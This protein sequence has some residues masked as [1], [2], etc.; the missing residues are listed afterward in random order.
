[1]AAVVPSPNQIPIF[2]ELEGTSPPRRRHLRV[3]P[4][5]LADLTARQRRAVTWGEGPLLVVAGAG[6]GKTTVLTRR[7]AWL[8]AEQRARPSEILA[9]T[10]TERAAAEMQERVDQLVPYGYADSVICTFHAFGD[11]LIRE[12]ALGA[13]LSD[14]V[15]VLSRPEQVTFLREHLDEL[16]LD[17][18]RPLGDPT[19][20]L[21][22]LAAHFS[23]ARDEDAS[24][25][26]YRAAA[27]RISARAAADPDDAALAEEAARQ[28]ELAAAYETYER[29]L[30]AADR[31]DFGDQVGLALRLLRDRADILA[32]ERGRYRYILVDEFQ[33]TNHAQFELVQL[34]APAPSGNVTVV[35]DDDQS[36]YRFRGAALSN[37]LGFRAA[38]RR[39]GRVVL[40]DNFR[41]PQPVLDAAYRLI[42]HNDPDRLE[43]RERIDKR[44]RARGTGKRADQGAAAVRSIAHATTSDEADGVAESIA[45]SLASGRRAADHAILVRGNRD[46]D[47]YL[48]ALSLRRIPWRFSGTAG[49]YRQPE[50][51]V[52]LSFLRAL[53]DPEDSVSLFDLATS[54]IF[55]LTPDQASRALNRAS[56]RHLGLEVALRQGL[57]D[58][59]RATLRGASAAI[60]QRLIA[61]LD[62][63]RELAARLDA[64]EILYRFV[65]S[66]GWLARLAL[67]ARDSGPERLQNVARLFDILRR[68]SGIL[69]DPRL[70]FLV[71]RLDVLIQAGDDPATA[72]ANV[73][74]AEAVHVLTC[75][76]AKG[77]EF[78]I[79]F[80]VGMAQD[81]F[82]TRARR[83][84][85]DLPDELVREVA[86]DGDYHLAE[87]R[88]LCYVGM[89]RAR[90]SLVMSW[91]RD[92][93]E[94]PRRPSQFLLE[95]L[96]LGPALPA[97]IVRPSPME[98]IERLRPPTEAAPTRPVSKPRPGLVEEALTL[99]Y[100]QVS[101]Y[102][103]CPARYR[104]AHLI[105]LPTP[106][107][108]PL[109]VGRALHA[110]VQAFHRA[111]MAGSTL[112]LEELHT[113]L[114]QHWESSGFVTRA[115]ED[116]RRKAARDALGRFWEEQ[117]ASPAPVIGV[118]QE[119]AF[120]F[121]PDRV[122]GRID[123]IDRDPDG[124]I[125]VVDYKSGDVRDPA[126]AA[127][128]SRESLQL[129][130]YALA[131]E[132]KHG[133]PPDRLALH[134]LESGEVGVS[135]ATPARLEKA[136]SQIAATAAGI[137]AD[138]FDANPGPMRCASCPFRTICPDAA[139]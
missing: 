109:V 110:A 28:G 102:T 100:G 61:A 105:R 48:R 129:A 32:T 57:A 126:T 5:L 128:R 82:P 10:F 99:S 96:D 12:H 77:L 1:M 47:P 21:S 103:D 114:D 69:R 49:L 123:R 120:R 24:P 134:F 64:G 94:R 16:P 36:I 104:Y 54:D 6:T 37:I 122:R 60:A 4:P 67:E 132:A 55:G 116:S 17:R 11:R 121:G 84:A 70:P 76:K 131:W 26:E 139:R 27:D 95:A 78:P 89:T 91:A 18:Y 138:R 111:Q 41:S 13:G 113:E 23:R 68:A 45:A 85:V 101:D 59:D 79:V 93:G 88:R 73:D 65:T 72:D 137:R 15:A 90:E 119:F 34:L 14:Q 39:T 56:R 83:D 31:I 42:R 63:H 43:V 74:A 46:A 9:L 118:E 2:E 80:M 127:R 133:R 75:H 81:R 108:H 40:T 35:G 44:L 135:Q 30:R 92:E 3:Q 115:H 8:I 7:I 136:R 124:S 125:G 33:D 117:H 38:Y 106:V 52:L 112:S 53:N 29:L 107:S 22:V 71:A 51:R 87:E 50:V 130:M 97:D 98:R 62:A 19:R 66:S 20:F 58:P 86:V 25:A